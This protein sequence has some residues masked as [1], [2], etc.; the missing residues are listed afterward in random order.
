MFEKLKAKLLGH[1]EFYSD[2]AAS[3]VAM[4]QLYFDKVMSEVDVLN[5]THWS[6]GQQYDRIRLSL[7]DKAMER[8]IAKEAVAAGL[9]PAY[10][11]IIVNQYFFA[12]E[13]QR[14]FDRN[15]WVKRVLNRKQVDYFPDPWAVRKALQPEG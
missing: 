7:D 8:I 10:L 12:D 15:Q 3:Q 1:A 13:L 6:R 2:L 9:N 4:Y 14:E 11:Q 5:N